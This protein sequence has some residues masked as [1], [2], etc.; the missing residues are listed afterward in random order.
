MAASILMDS[1]LMA[2]GYAVTMG[3]SESEAHLFARNYDCPVTAKSLKNDYTHFVNRRNELNR[4][5]HK[6]QVGSVNPKT[7]ENRYIEF[8]EFDDA[9]RLVNFLRENDIPA[10]HSMKDCK[11][12]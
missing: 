6:H 5:N 1:Y 11:C 12:R 3:E 10:W 2:F 7:G 4:C 9:D 8:K